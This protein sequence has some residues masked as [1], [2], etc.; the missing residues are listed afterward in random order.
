MLKGHSKGC[1]IKKSICSEPGKQR[2]VARDSYYGSSNIEPV[3]SVCAARL[4]GKIVSGEA[5]HAFHSAA[6][7]GYRRHA[8]QPPI[9][10]LGS[11]PR[12]AAAGACVR[13][14]GR[15]GDRA[16]AYIRVAHRAATQL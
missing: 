2:K 12:G 7:D 15:A 5:F 14:R 4:N 8:A 3:P 11:R 9:S 16:Q 13:D 6:G 1:G 10:D